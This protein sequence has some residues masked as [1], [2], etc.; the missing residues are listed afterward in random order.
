[1][2]TYLMSLGVEA[3]APA[4][5]GYEEPN[6]MTSEK[7]AK[8]NLIANAKAMNAILSGLCEYEFIKVMHCETTK[9]IWVKL[10]NIHEGDKK[11]NI[12]KLQVYRMHF[13]TLKM[14]EDEH[15][16]KLFL[17]FDEVVNVMMDLGETIKESVIV[18]KI[19]RSSP[20]K[21]NTK[22]SAIEETPNF[23]I[24]NMDQLLGFLKTYEMRI[25][26]GKVVTR[27]ANF[28]A[29]KSIEEN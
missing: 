15:I 24:L 9:Y 18:Q 8:L 4:M 20:S 17:R 14:N 6:E 1:M 25:M 13:E 21:F 2:K 19:L 23:D 12:A 26:E 11:V 3:W 16:A 10:E 29:D 22:V 5:V 27:E 28:K 7:Y